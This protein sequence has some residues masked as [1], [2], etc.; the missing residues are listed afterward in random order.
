MSTN[1]KVTGFVFITGW[2]VFSA[3]WVINPVKRF[4]SGSATGIEILAT[5]IYFVMTVL[6]TVIVK[7][8]LETPRR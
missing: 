1:N 7:S 3:L 5:I 4:I 2:L 8:I 6:A